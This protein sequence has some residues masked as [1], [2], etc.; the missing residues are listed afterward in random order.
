VGVLLVGLL[1]GAL[2]TFQLTYDARNVSTQ[3]R[4]LLWQNVFDLIAAS[5]LTGVGFGQL[6]FAWTL[7][8]FATRAPDVFDHAH[9]FALQW[10]V[11]FGLP[12]AALLCGLLGYALYLSIRQPSRAADQS[13]W[14]ALAMIAVALIHSLVEFPLWFLHFLLPLAAVFA[15]ASAEGDVNRSRAAPTAQRASPQSTH[16][17]MVTSV[18]ACVVIAFSITVAAWYWRGATRVT[19]IYENANAPERASESAL[20]AATHPTLGHY[21]DYAL[22]MLEDIDAPLSRFSRTTRALIDERLLLSWAR[23]HER[24]GDTRRANFLYDRAREF[25]SL[26]EQL[27]GPTQN[28]TLTAPNSAS[29]PLS[30]RDF[31]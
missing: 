10:A 11:E 21:G 20:L 6:N 13:K 8:P 18:L 14:P 23:A 17:R 12:V 3:H 5:P 16:A 24:S 30:A 28:L 15:L 1:V 4:V 9:N 25:A 26:R 2:L 31:R 22:I 19:D 29:M 27:G 7:T